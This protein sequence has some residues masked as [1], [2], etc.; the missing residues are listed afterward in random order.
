MEHGLNYFI[1]T[2]AFIEGNK[3]L[4][5]P[6][7]KAHKRLLETIKAGDE[8]HKIIVLA[9]GAGK[10]GVI[11]LAPYGISKGRVLVITPSLVIRQ[12][13][14]DEFDTRT[15]FNFWTD[16]KVILDDTKLP[17]VYRY[18]GYNTPS[19]KKRVLK[20]LD[21]SNIVI[22]NI[23]KVFNKKSEKPLVSILDS[24]FFDMIIIDE[25]H[26]A[27]ADSWLNTLEYFDAKKIVKLTATPYRADEKELGGDIIYTYDLGDA[28]GDSIVKNIVCEDYTTQKL[29]F[30]I[31]GEIVDKETALDRMDKGWVTRSVAYSIEC[32]KTIVEMSL[33]KLNEKRN[34]GKAHHQIIAVACGIEHAK[35]I[36]SLYREYGL[37]ADYVASDRPLLES[38]KIIIDFKKGILDVIVNVDMLAEG[39]DHP[40]ISIAAIFRPFRTLAPYAQF[41]GRSL[42]KIQGEDINN[43]IDNIA[44]VIYHKELNLDDLWEY[45]TGQKEQ[46]ERKKVI[47]LEYI[48]EEFSEKSRSIGVVK[49][50]GDIIYSAQTFLSDNVNNEYSNAIYESIRGL[51]NET[52]KTVEMMKSAGASNEEIEDF[53][54]FKRKK[55]D[56]KIT[57]KRDKL[58]EELIREGLQIH[59]KDDIISQ[60]NNLF[61]T[62]KLDPKGN[63]LPINTSSMFLKSSNTNDEYIAKYINNN[64]KKKLKRGID[65][66]ETYDFEQASILLPILIE[67]L[68]EKMERLRYKNE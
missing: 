2:D 17:K 54:A 26:H 29:E 62:T 47:E 49:T 9:T 32:S 46:A 3:W 48:R 66:W 1:D 12:G 55:L 6:Q 24:G 58:R 34:L 21:E 50:S 63:E 35:Q 15:D 4:R 61:V 37:K 59:H 42:R 22:A 28:I 57:S 53:R 41:I 23:H 33:K 65:E 31:D 51:E 19:D 18:A 64:L 30:Q 27:A 38:E 13:I 36:M 67:K 52:N 14:Y 56:E 20:Y 43:S 11:A 5:Y 7:R 39:F 10:T 44:H 25:A 68:K 45:Y 8:S 16:K 60:V 40:N